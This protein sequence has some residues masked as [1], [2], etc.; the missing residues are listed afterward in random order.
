MHTEWET[1]WNSP[2]PKPEVPPPPPSQLE[3]NPSHLRNL[4][5]QQ[6]LCVFTQTLE[7]PH[8]VLYVVGSVQVEP[9]NQNK[10]FKIHMEGVHK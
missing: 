7:K 3:H 5:L 10:H 6:R 8:C 4:K 2:S 9:G 1:H